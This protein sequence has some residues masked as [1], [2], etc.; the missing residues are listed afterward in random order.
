M[1]WKG[2]RDA[3]RVVRYSGGSGGG[4]FFRGWGPVEGFGAVGWGEVGEVLGWFGVGWGD[5]VDG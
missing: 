1:L 4:G 2:A 5:W 3:S